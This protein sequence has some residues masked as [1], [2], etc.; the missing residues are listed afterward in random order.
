MFLHWAS[1]LNFNIPA[2]CFLRN[3]FLEQINLV[4]RG[5]RQLGNFID[6][7]VASMVPTLT[8]YAP[9]AEN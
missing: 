2:D 1:N 4:C 7:S 5:C 6:N 8:F 9:A 3:V